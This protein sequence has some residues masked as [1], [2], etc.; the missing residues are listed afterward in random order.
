[1]IAK[2]LAS[3]REQREQLRAEVEKYKECDPQVVEEI[4]Q[5]DKVAKEAANR[6]NEACSM[7]PLLFV[8]S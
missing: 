2:E 1:M 3:L 4:C 6:W 8:P 5:V 7:D